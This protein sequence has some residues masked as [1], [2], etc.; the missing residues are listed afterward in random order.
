VN[1]DHS[2]LNEF[3]G[4]SIPGNPSKN[5]CEAILFGGGYRDFAGFGDLKGFSK[6]ILPERS[7]PFLSV[8]APHG[9]KIDEVFKIRNYLAP[10][11]AVQQNGHW[12]V[13]TRMFTSSSDSLSPVAS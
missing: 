4:V 7:N 6:K 2:K 1:V 10:I 8:D 9:T 11:T 3:V 12:T 5:L 13:C